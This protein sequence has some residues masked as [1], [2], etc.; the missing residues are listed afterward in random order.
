MSTRTRTELRDDVLRD[1]NV[2]ATGQSAAA[3]DAAL[4][5]E[6]VLDMLDFLDDEGV[7]TWD[8]DADAIPRRAY[9]PLVRIVSASLVGDFGKQPEAAYYEARADMA[10]K[11]LRRQ[12][13]A[14][15][16]PTPVQVDYF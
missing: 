8:K 2:L 1:L 7:I 16:L 12:A 10:L 14:A 9:R 5:Y 6:A 11:M 13:E 3:D 15:Y 4:A